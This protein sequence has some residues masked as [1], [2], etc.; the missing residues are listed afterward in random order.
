MIA[1]IKGKL[2]VKDPTYVVVEANSIGY[3]AKISLYT[4]SAIKEVEDALIYTWVHIKEDAHTLYGFSSEKERNVFL[5][6]TSISGIGPGTALVMLSSLNPNEVRKAIAQE[7]VRTIQAVKGIGPKT[8]QRVIL[9]LKDKMRKIEL[10]PG[11][12][13]S[14]SVSSSNNTRQEAFNALVTLGFAR[15]AA[16]KNIDTVLK[17][18]GEDIS[19]EDLIKWALKSS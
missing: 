16:E 2:T 13:K 1:Y 4:Y 17:Q 18:K 9:E 14:F 6:L 3:H 8:A 10:L 19:L 12:D 5:D 7:D 15:S 11:E